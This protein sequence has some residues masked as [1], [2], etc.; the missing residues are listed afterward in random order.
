MDHQLQK[1]F[2]FG[3]EAQGFFAAGGGHAY[4]P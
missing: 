4:L 1:L 2:D 3:L